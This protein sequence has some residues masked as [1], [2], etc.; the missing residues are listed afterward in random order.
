MTITVSIIRRVS[1]YA[2]SINKC[3]QPLSTN[4]QTAQA[5]SKWEFSE[6]DRRNGLDNKTEY[7]NGQQ[8]HV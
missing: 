7:L 8:R 2:Q 5:L 6:C 1:K 3:S 4:Q